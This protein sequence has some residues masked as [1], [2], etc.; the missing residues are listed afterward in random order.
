MAKVTAPL[1]SSEA[2]GKVGG[3]VYNTWRGISYVRT[4][5]TPVTQGSPAQ[6]AVQ[7][8]FESCRLR[9]YT[10]S[11]AQRALWTDYANSHPRSD[12]ASNTIR[13]SGFNAFRQ[14]NFRLQHAGGAWL[15]DPPIDPNQVV[16]STLAG[17]Q[18]GADIDV[19]WTL[20]PPIEVDTHWTNLW[21]SFP[22][23]AGRQPKIEDCHHVL[24]ADATDLAATIAHG[25]AG[26][27]GIFARTVHKTSG[28]VSPW[29]LALAD[30]TAEQEA[31]SQGPSLPTDARQGGPGIIWD[32]PN[33]ILVQ[34]DTY[35]SVTL[36]QEEASRLLLADDF[37][38]AIPPGATILGVTATI[39]LRSNSA[40][41]QPLQL[42]CL[43]LP[44][45]DQKFI[46]PAP[47]FTTQQFG[48]TADD[49]D[50]ILAP[51]IINDA[52]FALGFSPYNALALPLTLDYAWITLT[53]YYTL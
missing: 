53:V 3:V 7:A 46:S 44:L 32:D 36:Q 1:H 13:M 9:W 39:R 8:L 30:V 38:F 6:L 4:R 29:T 33:N 50:A 51:E 41:L 11:D 49:W 5:V 23:S 25:G 16:I 2:R 10:L 42:Y 43:D 18:D 47:A 20:L 31:L 34:D 15:D 48:G 12:W 24:Y 37:D 35:A 19:S 14:C 45:G 22:M 52:S 17:V 21:L 40:D 26:H 27:Y 28:L